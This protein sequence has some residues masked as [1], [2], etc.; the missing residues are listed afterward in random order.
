M[1]YLKRW[2]SSRDELRPRGCRLGKRDV[3]RRDRW[4]LYLSRTQASSHALSEGEDGC[5]VSDADLAEPK[6]RIAK[7]D[8]GRP[9]GRKPTQTMRKDQSC[10]AECPRTNFNVCKLCRDPNIKAVVS[11]EDNMPG[12]RL[13][14]SGIKTVQAQWLSPGAPHKLPSS[15]R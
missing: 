13:E 5:K 15:S 12:N 11:V 1:Q 3:E 4:L 14:S 2:S 8:R 7:F 9:I 6:D 10:P